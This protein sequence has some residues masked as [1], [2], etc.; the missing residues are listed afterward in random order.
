MNLIIFK[1]DGSYYVRPD[2]TLE[3]EARDFYIPHG[4][5]EV[6]GCRCFYTRII[7]AGKAVSEKF[8]ARYFDSVGEGCLLYCDGEP[9]TDNS[10]LLKPE[11]R[12]LQ[13]NAAAVAGQ[14]SDTELAARLTEA[15]VAVTARTS[16]RIGDLLI[17]ED[18]ERITLRQ[19]DTFEHIS[20]R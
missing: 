12:P 15:L 18:P 20:L 10:S 8:A 3:R 17:L 16:V 7:K 9:W 5:S 6:C 11:M 13:A 4:C 14:P 1:S 19:G 2:T